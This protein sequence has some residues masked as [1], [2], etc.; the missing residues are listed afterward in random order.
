VRLSLA[1]D[2][3]IDVL[4]LPPP[5]RHELLDRQDVQGAV[6]V[7]RQCHAGRFNFFEPPAG[8]EAVSFREYLFE[9]RLGGAV[10]VVIDGRRNPQQHQQT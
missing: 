6:L 7:V 8:V 9:H 1:A 10:V 3:V 5:G 4:T 2:Q